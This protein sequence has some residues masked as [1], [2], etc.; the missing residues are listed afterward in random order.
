MFITLSVSIKIKKQ[1]QNKTQ[2]RQKRTT[3]YKYETII[4]NSN[5]MLNATF[6]T[7]KLKHDFYNVNYMELK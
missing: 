5:N 1:K 2:I 3:M 4:A 7:S 6:K